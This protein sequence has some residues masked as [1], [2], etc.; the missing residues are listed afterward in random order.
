MPIAIKDDVASHELDAY[1]TLRVNIGFQLAEDD[2]KTIVVTSSTRGGEEKS[3]SALSLAIAY[4]QSGR[5]TLLID[6]DAR[7]PALHRYMTG[8][9]GQGLVPYLTRECRLEDAIQATNISRLSVMT[10]GSATASPSELLTSE[11]MLDLLEWSGSSYD[12][13]ILDTP[14]LIDCIE[15]KYLAAK[16]GGALMV[17]K[18]GKVKRDLAKKAQEVLAGANAKLLGAVLVK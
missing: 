9:S 6:A 17:M 18:I 2:L 10:S 4:A 7:K 11:R 1:Q 15:S 8:D 5:R 13:V 12:I 16:C 3:R 14:P